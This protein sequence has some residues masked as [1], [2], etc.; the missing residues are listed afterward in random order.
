MLPDGRECPQ[1][2]Q[3]G[4][5]DR[6]VSARTNAASQIERYEAMC[7]NKTKEMRTRLSNAKIYLV[8]ALKSATIYVNGDIARLF[9]PRTCRRRHRRSP[10]PPCGTRSTTS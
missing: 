3:S 4:N 5:E 1:R 2:D 9:P 10:R 8:D 6:E 7:E